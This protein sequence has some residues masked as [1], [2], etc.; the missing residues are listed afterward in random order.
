MLIDTGRC[1]ARNL[2]GKNE[3][4]GCSWLIW[5]RNHLEIRILDVDDLQNGVWTQHMSSGAEG[6]EVWEEMTRNSFW[7]IFCRSCHRSVCQSVSWQ[8]HQ[9]GKSVTPSQI[10]RK[11][12]VYRNLSRRKICPPPVYVSD[13][14]TDSKKNWLGFFQL[15]LTS[16]WLKLQGP[17]HP[18]S[19]I[20][21]RV[22]E[23]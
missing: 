15:P 22:F 12:A 13:I 23:R 9:G 10:V 17:L 5:P 8:I 3:V 16:H 2:C 11:I 7:Q 18:P 21:E 1:N 14:L 20:V 19:M 4:E 6:S